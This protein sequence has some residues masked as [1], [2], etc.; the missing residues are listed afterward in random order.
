MAARIGTVS[1]TALVPGI[2]RNGRLYTRETIASAV[3]RAQERIA[4]GT[5][6]LTMLTH[7]AAGDDSTRIVGSLTSLTLAEDGSAKFTADLADTDH[8]RTIARLGSG[9]TPHL[10]G[11]SIRGAWLGKVHREPGPAGRTVERGDDLELDGLDFTRTPGV[12]G[13]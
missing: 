4:A 7:H 11:V 13:A 12:V 9:A 6:P 3:A 2:S 8:A 10:R 1:G 5:E